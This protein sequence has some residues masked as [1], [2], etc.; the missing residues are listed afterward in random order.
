MSASAEIIPYGQDGCSFIKYNFAPGRRVCVIRDYG[1]EF[2]SFEAWKN[3]L[4]W[5][6]VAKNNGWL[7]RRG[8]LP[9]WP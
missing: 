6:K 3:T 5:W 1:M 8:H 7:N 9:Q 4:A 2:E